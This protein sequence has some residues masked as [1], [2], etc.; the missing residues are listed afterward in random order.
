MRPWVV[1]CGLF[2]AFFGLYFL[3]AEIGRIMASGD[4]LYESVPAYFGRR[5]LWEPAMFLGY[6]LFA[7]PNQQMWYPAAWMRVFSWSY[8]LFAVAPFP[9]AAIGMA[10]YLRSLTKST[11]AGIVAG[12]GYALGA[13]MISHAGHLM[14][15]HPAAWAPFVLW[16][17]ESLRQRGDA[18]PLVGGA[19]ALGLCGVAGQP[20]IFV[21]TITLALAYALASA[22]RAPG[23]SQVFLWRVVAM[24]A[25]GIAFSATQL[26]PEAFLAQ[27]STRASLDFGA[28]TLYEVPAGQ[29][30]LRIVFPYLF[31]TTALP[32]YPYSRIDFG[33]FTEETV[34]AGLVLLC[35][36]FV[37][38]RGFAADRRIAFW[39]FVAIV[40]LVLAV[41]DAT[42][43]ARVVHRLPVYGLF[44]APGRHAFE[45]SFAVAVLAG[46]GT[47]A[48]VGKRAVPGSVPFAF[49]AAACVVA[50]AFA[51]LFTQAGALR[52]IAAAYG[53]DASQLTSPFGNGALW[54]PLA[55]G[56]FGLVLVLLAAR[57]ARKDVAG[58]LLVV[59]TALDVGTFGWAA[60]WN[61]GAV[62]PDRLQA[63]PEVAAAVADAGVASTRVAWLPGTLGPALAPNLS[64][65]WGMRSIDGYT[66]LVPRRVAALLGVTL[67]G[68]V[69]L[70][71]DLNDRS[72][73]V[74]GVS[75]VL[76]PTEPA[77]PVVASRPFAASD[78]HVFL[79]A[80]G[81][82]ARLNAAFGLPVPVPATGVALVSE[83]GES[84]LIAQGTPVADLEISYVNGKR[85][86]HLIVAGRDTAEFAYDRADVR[87]VVRHRRASI[88]DGDA[89]THRYVALIPVADYVPVRRVEIRWRYPAALA[90][91]LTIDKLSLVDA[92][93]GTAE[94]FGSLA[95]FYASPEHWRPIAGPGPGIVAF[96]NE[97]ALPRAWLARPVGVDAA[98]ALTAV[99]TGELPSGEH[100]DPRNLALVETDTPRVDAPSASDRVRIE[101]ESSSALQLET[102]CVAT[103]FPIV[104]NSFDSNWRAD[105]DGV[106]STILSTDVALSGIVVAPGTHHVRFRFV[107]ISLFVGFG[108]TALAVVLSFY[109]IVRTARQIG[110][111]GKAEKSHGP[112]F[113][114]Q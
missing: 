97:D 64:L 98:Q 60:Y 29:L 74:A 106:P 104:R 78:V 69:V 57:F 94:A 88:F 9:L 50:A 32:Q 101:S 90:G 47:A 82:S 62:G 52:P 77:A 16:A 87:P 24:L 58:A 27:E 92:R 3:P 70:S 111:R 15:S 42:P 45:W 96:Q 14:L 61:W 102:R 55:T 33:T 43:V 40:A 112:C 81:E 17:V 34:A 6:P 46:Y 107:P 12:L 59:A 4:A 63:P 48:I 99:R 83:L 71:S 66:P 85:E 103:C 21:S 80:R 7:D 68:G 30:A 95:Q 113:H 72:F 67:S 44:R 108:V 22:S 13:F 10:G 25:L 56:G 109:L 110:A 51:Q 36:S 53:V 114:V 84:M 38:V 18:R 5:E 39:A 75:P 49:G 91:A 41:G 11:I 8:N 2:I 31:G 65:L 105:I 26:I 93:R 37:A 76:A 19:L 54:I 28:F 86:H 35:L 20:Q 23:G 89:V 1:T 100:F 79:A 73:D